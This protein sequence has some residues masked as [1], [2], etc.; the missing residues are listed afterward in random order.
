MESIVL[1]ATSKEN[2]VFGKSCSG[3]A[4][5]IPPGERLINTLIVQLGSEQLFERFESAE[6]FKELMHELLA[7]Q[8][9]H[10]RNLCT[11]SR[12]CATTYVVTAKKP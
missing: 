9:N 10:K 7:L 8:V 3:C 12:L 11:C 1:P 4:C 2:G 6:V 5:P